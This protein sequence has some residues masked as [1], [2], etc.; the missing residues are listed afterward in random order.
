MECLYWPWITFR[1]T[2]DVNRFEKKILAEMVMDFS[3]F[4]LCTIY[5]DVFRLN[6]LMD[7]N[8][9]LDGIIDVYCHCSAYIFWLIKISNKDSS[10]RREHISIFPTQFLRSKTK[11]KFVIHLWKN[12]RLPFSFSLC[13]SL[14][15]CL[16]LCIEYKTTKIVSQ[17]IFKVHNRIPKNRRWR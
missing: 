13:L 14:C 16:C 1:W 9:N 8:V 17:L 7:R 6:N 10:V 4:E 3:C 11:R 15:L 2:N 5:D 12:G